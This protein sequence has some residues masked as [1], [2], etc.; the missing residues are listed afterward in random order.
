MSSAIILNKSRINISYNTKEK[1]EKYEQHLTSILPQL[2]FASTIF[3]ICYR[4]TLF[5]YFNASQT[6]QVLQSL[7]FFFP[8][9]F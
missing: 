1:K 9:K 8:N 2:L 3:L 7:L 4:T 5:D 6:F